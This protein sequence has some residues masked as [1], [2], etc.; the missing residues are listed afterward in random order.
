MNNEY[1]K[2]NLRAQE[3]NDKVSP[4]G[5]DLL[6]IGSV[7]YNPEA[8]TKESDLDLLGICDFSKID[9]A[10]LYEILGVEYDK[11]V[12]HNAKNGLINNL[13]IVWMAD[14]F[15]TGLHLWDISAF[16]NVVNLAGPNTTFRSEKPDGAVK[17]LQA[18]ADKQIFRSLSGHEKEV[19]KEPK[20]IPGGVALKFFPYLKDGSEFYPN[21]QIYNLLLDPVIMAKNKTYIET[22]LQHM[23]GML[24]NKLQRIC[25][26]NHRK[27]I[28]LLTPLPEKIKEKIPQELKIKLETFF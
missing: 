27:E 20:K 25:G 13:S 4:L 7:A 22:G 19:D 21:I 1:A 16:N 2:R 14:G 8:V 9:F 11:D 6:I 28:N 5:L 24:K 26:T 17:Q 15:E 12:A 23:K 3:I 18:R 10:K